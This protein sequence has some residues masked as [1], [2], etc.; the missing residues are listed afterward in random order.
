MTPALL[1]LMLA[2]PAAPADPAAFLD[3]ANLEGRTDLWTI[4]DKGIVGE[5]KEDPKYNTFL[6]TKARYADFELKCKVTLRDGVGNSGIQIRS[7]KY[8]EDEKKPFRVKGPQVDIG[9]SY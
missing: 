8:P 6:C 9:K 2:A 4:T 7:E 5:T 3:R 1:A